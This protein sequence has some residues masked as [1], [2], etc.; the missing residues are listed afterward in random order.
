MPSIEMK[1]ITQEELRSLQALSDVA[2]EHGIEMRIVIAPYLP[3]Y[4]AKLKNFSQWKA[5]LQAALPQVQIVDLSSEL[6]D[7]ASFADRLHTNFRGSG[8]ILDALQRQG[9]FASLQ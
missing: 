1:T 6:T 5:E 3:A 8:A 7:T 4:R 9:M 2:I